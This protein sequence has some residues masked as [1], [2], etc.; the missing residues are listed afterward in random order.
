MQDHDLDDFSPPSKKIN[1]KNDPIY[2][3]NTK[4]YP[5][6]EYQKLKQVRLKASATTAES[7]NKSHGVS[8]T[9]VSKHMVIQFLLRSSS[10]IAVMTI[11]SDQ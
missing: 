2:S 7:V 11:G 10:Y 5:Q 6:Q 9:D 1:Q 8:T 4:I 3:E